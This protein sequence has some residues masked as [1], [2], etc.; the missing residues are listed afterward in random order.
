MKNFEKQFRLVVEIIRTKQTREKER[1]NELNIE[2]MRANALISPSASSLQKRKQIEN[3]AFLYYIN[4]S[5]YISNQLI[6][7][8]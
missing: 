1:P 8:N 5:L 6:S 2:N 4:I 7:T 3:G